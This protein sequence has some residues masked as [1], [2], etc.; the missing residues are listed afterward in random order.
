MALG[1]VRNVVSER[2]IPEYAKFALFD[3]SLYGLLTNKPPLLCEFTSLVTSWVKSPL[4]G[5]IERNGQITGFGILAWVPPWIF[6]CRSWSATRSNIGDPMQYRRPDPPASTTSGMGCW[7]V[8]WWTNRLAWPHVKRARG[9]RVHHLL[10]SCPFVF[11]WCSSAF[12]LFVCLICFV[13]SVNFLSKVLSDEKLSNVNVRTYR[14]RVLP[15]RQLLVTPFDF[16]RRNVSG[17]T[18]EL[19]QGMTFDFGCGYLRSVLR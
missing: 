1:P 4:D 7:M 12:V 5:R 19:N 15:H 14:T 11:D 13:V 8:W 2:Q 18:S 9:A 17:S 6:R 16:P 10:I 3:I